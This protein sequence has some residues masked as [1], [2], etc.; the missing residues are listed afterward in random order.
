M[1]VAQMQNYVLESHF[2]HTKDIIALERK[3][4]KNSEEIT[5]V[6]ETVRKDMRTLESQVENLKEQM[7]SQQQQQNAVTLMRRSLADQVT[8]PPAEWTDN[9]SKEHIAQAYLDEAEDCEQVVV[10]LREQAEGLCSTRKL[11]TLKLL[12]APKG[13]DGQVQAEFAC[14][15]CG[16]ASV[17]ELLGHVGSAHGLQQEVNQADEDGKE[18][19]LSA[20]WDGGQTPTHVPPRRPKAVEIKVPAEA[21]D[22]TPKQEE[23]ETEPEAAD[24]NETIADGIMETDTKITSSPATPTATP[25]TI[26]KW[27]PL[28]VRQMPPSPAIIKPTNTETF[29]WEFLKLNLGGEQW[30]PGFYFIGPNSPLASKFKAYWI[31]DAHWEPFLPSSP[32][33]HGANSR[34]SSIRL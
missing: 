13:A 12:D 18:G 21:D 2:G 32:G 4:R 22:G 7:A 24:K 25:T 28:P 15:G 8:A 19:P 27:Y 17:R 16:H 3:G 20:D 33:Q 29:T 9:F 14:C 23:V 26:S 30:S 11:V 5:S 10:K 34:P 6:K 1:E 31:L